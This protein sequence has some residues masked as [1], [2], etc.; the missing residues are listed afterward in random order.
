MV[1]A[2]YER[3][4]AQI[5]ALT[6]ELV[7]AVA[8][9]EASDARLTSVERGAAV[10]AREA[11]LTSAEAIAVLNGKLLALQKQLRAATVESTELLEE[12]NALRRQGHAREAQVEAQVKQARVAWEDE[13]AR[14]LAQFGQRPAVAPPT[15]P[16]PVAVGGVDGLESELAMTIKKLWQAR[17]ER[18]LAVAELNESRAKEQE[19]ATNAK[20]AAS[21]HAVLAGN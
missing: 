14:L 10:A 20:I 13:K 4:Q 5:E 12:I 11:G 9:R 19:S 3:L 8:T 7:A 17:R 15:L 16:T 18:E 2:N 1:Q 21:K 6:G